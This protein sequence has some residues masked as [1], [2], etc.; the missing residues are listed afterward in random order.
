MGELEPLLNLEGGL[1]A[2]RVVDGDFGGQVIAQG[3]A[4]AAERADAHEA[5][6]DRKEESLGSHGGPSEEV[7]SIVAQ[8]GSRSKSVGGGFGSGALICA[9]EG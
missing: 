4:D 3:V 6:E 2:A 9:T 1:R 7:A 5:K 8:A